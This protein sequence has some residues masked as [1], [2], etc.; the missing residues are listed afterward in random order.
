M[1]ILLEA[2][3]RIGVRRITRNPEGGVGGGGVI[4]RAVLALFGLLLAFTVSGAGGRFDAR[5][6]PIVEETNAMETMK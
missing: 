5:R 1:L 4:D 6:V 2:G 3:R